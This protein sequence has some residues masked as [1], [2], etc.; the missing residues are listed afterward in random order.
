MATTMRSHLKDFPEPGIEAQ[1]ANFTVNE[2]GS[3]RNHLSLASHL[4]ILRHLW[5]HNPDPVGARVTS[6]LQVIAVHGGIPSKPERVASFAEATHADV[7]WM[8]G[9]HDVHAQQ[10][11]RVAQLLLDLA[12][13]VDR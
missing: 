1:L 9:H 2:D 7:H 4:T 5:E 6:P 11:E 13:R 10:P 12:D 8:D 3:I